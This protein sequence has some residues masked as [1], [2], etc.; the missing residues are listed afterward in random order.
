MKTAFFFRSTINAGLLSL[1]MLA[2]A[3]C[4]PQ[5]AQPPRSVAAIAGVLHE[6][7]TNEPLG[8]V[9]VALVRA[10]DQT[11]VATGYTAAD[12]SFSFEEVPT[13]LYELRTNLL[14]YQRAGKIIRMQGAAQ[15][16]GA[17]PLLPVANQQVVVRPAFPVFIAAN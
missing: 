9:G 2:G 16:L 7:S 1:A 15:D 4:A 13:G 10:S 8:Y 3:S 11:E 14:G 6:Q 17:L 12:G 5:A